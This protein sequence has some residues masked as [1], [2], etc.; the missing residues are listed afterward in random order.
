[1]I[2]KFKPSLC[3]ISIALQNLGVKAQTM[4]ASRFAQLG[5][6]AGLN[7]LA[8]IYV[9]NLCNLRSLI[10]YCAQNNWNLRISSDLLPLYTLP[11]L[12][13]DLLDFPKVDYILDLFEENAK[14]IKQY[15]M[16]VSMHPDQFVVPA[17]AN[18]DVR[19]KSI[20]ELEYHGLILDLL[21][22]P[23]SYLAPLNIH[24]NFYKG[25]HAAIIGYFTES[26]AKLSHSVKNRL[27]LECE[28]KPNS[29]S[30]QELLQINQNLGIPI[31]FD[32]LH[33]FNNPKGLSALEAF[34]LCKKTWPVQ[35]WFHYS[36][37]RDDSLTAHADFCSDFPDFFNDDVTL[38][39]EFKMK[40][41]AIKKFL[42]ECK[43]T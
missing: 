43:T 21:D 29:W 11:E 7:R 20:K 19:A 13:C 30:V 15:K 37:H 2:R 33:H 38:D 27:V 36:W 22:V 39:F 8:D 24:M 32:C 35:P 12:N 42:D 4:T 9:N 34:D 28:D 26:Y 3:C 41:L 14:L 10:S 25:D 6:Q 18:P 40:D 23:Q 16:R 1:M 31:T 17:S 5:R